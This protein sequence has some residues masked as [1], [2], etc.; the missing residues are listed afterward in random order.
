MRRQ[1]NRA[2]LFNR[3]LDARSGGTRGRSGG[4]TATGRNGHHGWALVVSLMC[5]GV[6]LQGCAHPPRI[7]PPPEEATLQAVVLDLPQAR[8]W[9]GLEASTLWEVIVQSVD[10]E[11]AYRNISKWR[12]L[13][14]GN[15]LA[16]S[17]GGGNGAFGAGLLIGWTESGTRPPDFQ[18]VTGVSTG[19]LI[20]P[21][22][23]LG[24]AYDGPLSTLYTNVSAE[25]IYRERGPLAALLFDD[26]LVDSTPLRGLIAD[27]VDD[28]MVAAIAREYAR[29]RLLLIGTTNLDVRLPVIWNI[30]AIAASGHPGARDLIH[31]IMLASASIPGVFPPIMIDVE[32]N[33]EPFQ[34]MHVDG[35]TMAQVFLYPAGAGARAK[36]AGLER[37]RRA[38]I[39]RNGY[40][41]VDWSPV[42]RQTVEVAGRAI[43]TLV[44]ASSVNDIMR[45]YFV[46]ERDGV[47]FN[48]AFIGDDFEG[49]DQGDGFDPTYMQ[50]L[51]EYGYE[52]ARRGVEWHKIPPFMKRRSAP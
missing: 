43:D 17:G 13:P 19:A 44:Y 22:A 5:A 32:V 7:A 30:G 51:Y 34:E 46:A 41:G 6:V 16:I 3:P 2:V 38:F 39:I 45:M 29:G 25:N 36:A 33:G 26:G 18:I 52:K 50:A 9:P 49:P 12:D 47:D 8:F 42:E 27:N 35:G 21:Y 20:A 10:R 40:I 24:S 1:S 37:E 11:M 4:V 14:P 31:K 23:Y 48:Y 15:L 28:A